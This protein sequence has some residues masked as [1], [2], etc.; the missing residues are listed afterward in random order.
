MK[1]NCHYCP[2]RR[3]RMCAKF[4]ETINLI[5]VEDNVLEFIPAKECENDDR[6]INKKRT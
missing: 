5:R 1:N 2:D 3:G 4:N 6:R